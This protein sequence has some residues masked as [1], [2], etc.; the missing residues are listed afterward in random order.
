MKLRFDY[1]LILFALSLNACYAPSGAAPV[2]VQGQPGVAE[3]IQRVENGLL[4][5]VRPTAS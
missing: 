2:A 4:P 1:L 3:R 5:A